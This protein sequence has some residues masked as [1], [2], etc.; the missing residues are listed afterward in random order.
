M[1]PAIQSR[2]RDVQVIESAQDLPAG[3]TIGDAPVTVTLALKGG[4]S[5]AHTITVSPGSKGDP[6]TP[7]QLKA[8]WTDCLARGAGYLQDGAA[9]AQFDKGL[10]LADQP[11]FNAWL[12]ALRPQA[13]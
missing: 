4:K 12:S 6:L 9:S 10:K 11:D 1:R 13:S 8:K 2:L 5:L 3:V 7:T